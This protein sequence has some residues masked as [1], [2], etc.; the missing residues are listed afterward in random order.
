MAQSRQNHRSMMRTAASTLALSRGPVW[1]GRQ[2]GSA[3]MRCHL[4]IGSVDPRLVQTGFDDSDLGVVRDKKTR[5]TAK[6]CKGA[7]ERQSNKRPRFSQ[8]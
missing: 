8:R 3:V 5:H 6:R 2:H 4:G 7:C 1:P